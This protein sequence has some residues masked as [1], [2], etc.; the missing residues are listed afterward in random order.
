METIIR[1]SIGI[2]IA[3]ASFTACIC[4][5]SSICEIQHSEVVQFDNCKRGFNQL[6][7][8]VRKSKVVI[9]EPVFVMEA[10]GIYYE[11]L[12]YHLHKLGLQVSVV[13]PNKVKH[14]A[15]SLNVKSKTDIIDARLIG[16][17]GAERSLELWQPPCPVFKNLRA[18]TRL[19]CDLKG[20]KTIFQNRL[21][22]VEAGSEPVGFVIQ[23][24]KLIIAR[25]DKEIEKCEAEM[26]AVIQSE[27]WLNEKV[28]KL[29]TIPGVG[30]ITAA[31]VIAETQGFKLINN[32]K[33]LASY[34][35]YDVVERESG[36]SIKGRTKIS[37]KGNSRIRAALYFP[38]LVASRHNQKLKAVY[39]R[40]NKNKPS[41]M[42]G[43]VALQRKLIILMYTLWKKDTVY[44]H[45]EEKITSG[46][47]ETKPLLRLSDEVA[48]I[49]KTDRPSSL[50]AQDE[51]PSNQSTEALLRLT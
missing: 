37:K 46:N 35:G 2:D 47:Q 12:A 19:C 51:L 23:S 26:A 49:N 7:K 15:K 11:P 30:L 38:A 8:W 4:K 34:A 22:S 48:G 40:I 42:V 41:K 17:M 25:L 44:E 32:V 28:K 39:Q 14:Y 29:L 45:K 31:I 18:I 36:T 10:T 9:D 1:Q 3:K 33:Q 27:Q 13:L 50:S 6:L 5:Q 21:E 43:A 16:Q 24:T 20:Q